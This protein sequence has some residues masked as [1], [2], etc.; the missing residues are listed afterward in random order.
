MKRNLESWLTRGRAQLLSQ[1]TGSGLYK[2][3]S[4]FRIF[5]FGLVRTDKGDFQFSREDAELLLEDRE[6]RPRVTFD[7]EH[8]A[9]K[10]DTADEM[11]GAGSCLLELRD[12]GLWAVD[13]KYTPKAL[14]Q[15]QEG[16]RIYFSPAFLATKKG[17]HIIQ[18]INIALTGTPA[19]KDLGTLIAASRFSQPKE[20][21]AMAHKLGGYLQSHMKKSG[22]SLAQMA[23]KCGIQ[24]DRM[25]KLSDGEEPSE[26]EMSSAC[27]AMGVKDLSAFDGGDAEDEDDGSKDDDGE[28]DKEVEDKPAKPTT[29]SRRRD[30]DEDDAELDLVALTGTPDPVKQRARLHAMKAKADAFE[31]DHKTLE[32]LSAREEKR[33]R[34]RLVELGKTEGKLTPRLLKFY[35]TKSVEEFAEFLKHAPVVFHGGRGGE[36]LD[37]LDPKSPRAQLTREEL[38]VCKLSRID[39]DELAKFKAD[40]TKNEQAILNSYL[41]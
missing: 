35:A 27:K 33:E 30:D 41:V 29:T 22:L 9:L 5:S 12:D 40:P 24:A 19:M 34:E 36:Q 17:R 10:A 18:L 37:E 13:V 32:A 2:A 31:K 1:V 16:E 28:S 20:L 7:Y 6:G 14:R 21:H 4:E 25:Q 38:E 39:P 26:E 15:V 8:Q 3:L 11:I 23:E